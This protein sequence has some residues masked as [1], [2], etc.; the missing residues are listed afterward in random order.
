MHRLDGPLASREE[1][2]GRVVAVVD[3]GNA[4]PFGRKQPQV[5]R[6]VLAA[7][8]DEELQLLIDLLGLLD[9]SGK[10]CS[11]KL[12]EVAAG[13]KP[14]QVGRAEENLAVNSAQMTP[15]LALLPAPVAAT[16]WDVLEAFRRSS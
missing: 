5:P 13:E 3:I 11:I 12:R 10:A 9:Q 16:T 7:L 6:L 1:T 8:I 4:E 14:D 2:G 15:R